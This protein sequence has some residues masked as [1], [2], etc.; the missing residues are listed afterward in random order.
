[1]FMFERLT[2][3]K[4]AAFYE[5][6]KRAATGASDDSQISETKIVLTIS[7][8]APTERYEYRLE[9][10][11][12]GVI[13]SSFMDELRA[14]KPETTR[15]VLERDAA[16]EVFRQV[17]DARVLELPQISDKIEPDSLIMT[18]TIQSGEVAKLVQLPVF[19]Q[20]TEAARHLGQEAFAFPVREG[21]AIIR[22][23]AAP[24][25]IQ[26]L[27]ALGGVQDKSRQY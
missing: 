8:G 21:L 12:D 11:G 24:G 1:M 10:R 25:L 17:L 15:A 19:E 27:T 4:R 6:L 9:V 16:A 18:L 2:A 23:A 13:E 7:G 5:T 14:A 22:A 20:D 26:V 3:T